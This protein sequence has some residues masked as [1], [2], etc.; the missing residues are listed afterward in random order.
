MVR[1]H[2]AFMQVT[3]V[4][5]LALGCSVAQAQ[6]PRSVVRGVV[7]D[8]VSAE[9]LPGATVVLQPSDPLQGMVTDSLGAFIAGLVISSGRH[10]E[11]A[12]RYITPFQMLFS[13]I[14]F[15]S[16]TV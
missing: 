4:I 6:E 5:G 12:L 8:A 15:A 9:P 1:R 3:V 13:A 14:F 11:R 2:S 16:S 10:R 7:V